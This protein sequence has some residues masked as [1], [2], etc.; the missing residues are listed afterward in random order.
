M[1]QNRIVMVNTVAGNNVVSNVYVTK[2]KYC[3]AA[4]MVGINRFER[5]TQMTERM[6]ETAAKLSLL[7]RLNEINMSPSDR[8]LAKAHLVQAEL[9]ADTILGV[10]SSVRRWIDALLVNPIRR[11]IA[12]IW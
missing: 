7:D 11:G 2:L 1:Q 12:L 5:S 3:D 8:A 10:T 9:L 4:Y 6:I